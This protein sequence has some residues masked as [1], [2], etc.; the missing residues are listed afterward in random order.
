[1]LL[2]KGKSATFA[3]ACPARNAG[4]RAGTVAFASINTFCACGDN[5]SWYKNTTT[6]AEISITLTKGKFRVGLISFSGIIQPVY[7]ASQR[8]SQR[9]GRADISP[10]RKH[11]VRNGTRAS[12]GGATLPT[13]LQL[14]TKNLKVL[15]SM[16][17]RRHC[18]PILLAKP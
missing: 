8:K 10:V 18:L 7:R 3:G 17:A 4:K 15:L 1:M 2:N 11:W 12:P 16:S 9:R 14:A 5:V 6:F 13:P